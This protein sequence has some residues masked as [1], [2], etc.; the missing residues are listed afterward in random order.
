MAGLPQQQGLRALLQ[1]LPEHVQWQLQGMAPSDQ[2]PA[3]A[4]LQQAMQTAA[5]VRRAA[6]LGCR[7]L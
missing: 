5:E 6:L 4:Q 7:G 1:Q 3:L 2:V